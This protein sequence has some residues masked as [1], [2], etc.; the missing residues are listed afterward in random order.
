MSMLGVSFATQTLTRVR[1]PL[2]GDGHGNQVRDTGAV[3][4]EVE[5]PGCSIQPG[6][7]AEVL[8]GR[9]AV[10][11]LWT[12]YAPPGADVVALDLVRYAGVLYEVSGEPARWPSPT[13]SLDHMVVLLVR[14][15]G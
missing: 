6:A 15:E 5:V 9:D 8:A 2:V 13:G 11:V 12:V 1:Y 4:D 3:P 10:S 7:S 14:W